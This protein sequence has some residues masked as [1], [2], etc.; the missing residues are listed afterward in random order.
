VGGC[1]AE[2]ELSGS[3][4]TAGDGIGFRKLEQLDLVLRGDAEDVCGNGFEHVRFVH[5]ALPEISLEDISMGTTF[6][7]REFKLP[8]MIEAMTGGALGTETINRNLARA[9]EVLGIP[10]CLGSQR[11]MMESPGLAFT[12]QVR[13]VAP[14]VFLLGNLGGTQLRSLGAKAALWAMDAVGAD[15]LAIHLNPAQEMNQRGGDSDWTGVLDEIAL[16]CGLS[17]KPIVVKETGCGLSRDVASR[18]AATGVSALD[19]AGAGGTSWTMVESNR[20]SGRALVP[21]G[22][23]IRT[24]ESL[25]A[26]LEVTDKPLI[27]S[28]GMRTGHDAAKALA[29]GASLVGSARPLL[30]AAMDSPEAVEAVLLQM[31]R[32]LG[33]V[34]L[35]VG[36]GSLE[37]LRNVELR[38]DDRCSDLGLSLRG[39]RRP[40]SPLSHAG[41]VDEGGHQGVM[42]DSPRAR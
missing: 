2:S 5:N 4:E 29:L 33:T 24:A 40:G 8:F 36:A 13:D 19:V 6:L 17:A 25:I 20:N 7:G 34:M 11:A 16:L 26:C 9:A 22:W 18:L 31:A 23:G 3:M 42:R 27:A 14:S 37:E 12:Y 10:M 1:R 28:G 38:V 41:L 39:A 35:L 21:K 30:A 15:G 32:E